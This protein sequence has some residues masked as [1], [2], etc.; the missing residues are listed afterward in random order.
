MNLLLAFFRARLSPAGYLGLHLSM[1]AA[2]LLAAAAGFGAIAEDV[3]NAEA[4]TLLDVRLANW[5]H[6]HATPAFTQ[7]M[8]VLTEIHGVAGITILTLLLC[9]WLTGQRHHQ[10]VL[11]T[12]CTVGGG[13]LLNVAMKYAF[14][15]ARPHFD[16]PLLTLSTYSFPSG[17]TTGSTLFY[18]VL[19]CYLCSR[20]RQWQVRA[21]IILAAVLMIAL[22]GLS[23]MYLGVHYLSDVLA[24]VTEGSAWLALTVTTL[25]TLR[26]RRAFRGALERNHG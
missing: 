3:V 17:H 15:R 21:P 13:M 20:V 22:V 23:R 2:V 9:A 24:A 14:H 6:V 8:L 7:L 10:W 5:L 25:S 26:R 12:A 4:I 11:A 1:G 19:A 18:G 16:D